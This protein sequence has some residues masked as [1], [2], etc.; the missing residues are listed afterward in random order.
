MSERRRE[1]WLGSVRSRVTVAAAAVML[2]VLVVVAML[3]V[4]S[5]RT[6]LLDQLDESL[7]IDAE[8]VARAIERDGEPP[9]FDDDDRL[10]VV[11]VAGEIT[12]A[13]PDLDDAEAAAMVRSGE[14]ATRLDGEPH[15]VARAEVD[16]IEVFVATSTEDVDESVAALTRTLA[17]VVPAAGALLAAVVW[18]MVGRTLRPVE[19]IRTEVAAIGFDELGRRVPQPDGTDEVARLAETMNAML[20]R[21]DLANQRQQRFVGDASHELRT[22]LTRM[23]AVL[24]LDQRAPDRSDP[25]ATRRQVLDDVATLQRLIDDLLVLARSDATGTVASDPVDLDDLVLE[26]A[27]AVGGID[28]AD[29]SAAQVRGDPAALRRVVRNLLVNARRHAADTVRVALAEVGGDARLVVDDDGPGIPP[30]RRA[31]VF[32]RFSRLDDARTPGEG[33]SG[34][35]LSIVDALVTRH[36]GTVEVGDSPS[37][38]ARLTVAIPLAGPTAAGEP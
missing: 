12:A 27:R 22:P 37:G 9:S 2:A 30:D 20:E 17:V 14:G 24:E 15:R 4:L 1:R 35:G 28:V 6:V 13:T 33:R 8:R 32:E 5:Q 38:G 7:E 36:G 34:L 31:E 21:L 3:L 26:E 19:R 10:V 16:A 29:V 25:A 18:I 11:V 23:R